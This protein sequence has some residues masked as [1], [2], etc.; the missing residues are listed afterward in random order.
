MGYISLGVWRDLT[1]GHLYH[2]GERFP[3]DGRAVTE[4]R[5]S[6]LESG[7]NRAG[8]RLIRADGAETGLPE[9]S[10]VKA[11]ETA[12]E[13]RKTAPAAK[14]ARKTARKTTRK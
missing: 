6:E 8:M 3:F 5:I 14:A 4:K 12:S 10:A 13:A 2:E 1:D 9:G 11:P 7:L